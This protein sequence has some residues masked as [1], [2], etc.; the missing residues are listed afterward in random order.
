MY[1]QSHDD[2]RRTL[3]LDLQSTGGEVSEQHL[4]SLTDTRIHF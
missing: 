4:T 2:A 3:P 1:I